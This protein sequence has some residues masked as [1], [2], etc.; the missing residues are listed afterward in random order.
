MA[1][2]QSVR[3]G[4]NKLL[5]LLNGIPL[6]EHT[7]LHLQGLFRTIVVSAYPEVLTLARE[8]DFACVQNPFACEGASASIRLGLQAL[9]AQHANMAGCVF[10]VGDQPRL[11]TR[12]LQRLARAFLPTNKICSLA[13]KGERANPA[14]FPA[15]FFPEL[16]ALSKEQS[17]GR[18]IATHADELTLV[19]VA[20]AAEVQDADVPQL[21]LELR[22]KN[23]LVT[24]STCASDISCALL[25]MLSNSSKTSSMVHIVHDLEG[26]AMQKNARI[27]LLANL[28]AAP[29]KKAQT[30]RALWNGS[31]RVIACTAHVEQPLVCELAAQPNTLMI[32]IC[33]GEDARVHNVLGAML[34]EEYALNN[35]CASP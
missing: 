11:S 14:L 10:C 24:T 21:F 13:F 22:A 25:H 32:P 28:D 34:Q 12:S 2:G 8:Y 16:L 6:I 18:V 4:A 5:A 19:E 33:N 1:S 20:Q 7:F 3:F 29:L 27:L 15:R 31:K 35:P 9:L 17:G 26:Q 30:V 23:L